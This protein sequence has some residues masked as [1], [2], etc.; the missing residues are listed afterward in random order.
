MGRTCCVNLVLTGVWAGVVRPEPPR[1]TR[2]GL[3]MVVLGLTLNGSAHARRA[4]MH[5]DKNLLVTELYRLSALANAFA[6]VT[7]LVNAILVKTCA[8]QRPSGTRVAM[9]GRR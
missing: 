6:L 1:M 4:S 7:A 9:M 5:L 2:T 3:K 8:W